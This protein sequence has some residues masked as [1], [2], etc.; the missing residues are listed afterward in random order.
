[1]APRQRKKE[2]KQEKQKGKQS[3]F[4]FA[5]NAIRSRVCSGEKVQQ[6]SIN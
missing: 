6:V 1:M 3:D 4:F 5:L 2:A